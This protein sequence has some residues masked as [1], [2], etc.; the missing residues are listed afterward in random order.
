MKKSILLLLF[1]VSLTGLV[2]GQSLVEP[3]WGRFTGTPPEEVAG[4]SRQFGLSFDDLRMDKPNLNPVIAAAKDQYHESTVC[5]IDG[6]V[7][8]MT[9]VYYIDEQLG[10]Y[11]STL[12][13]ESND[14]GFINDHFVYWE[15]LI[16]DTL[17]WGPPSVTLR[18]PGTTLSW[19]QRNRWPAFTI[20]QSPITGT[21]H[22]ISFSQYSQFGI[23]QNDPVNHGALVQR[24]TNNDTTPTSPSTPARR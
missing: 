11:A 15:E 24:L 4:L 20:S 18:F 16:S 2:Y 8:T 7:V 12:M 3:V 9:A 13:L 21:R 19:L 1:C 6:S 10:Y 5:G 22:R 14:D 17:G 23:N